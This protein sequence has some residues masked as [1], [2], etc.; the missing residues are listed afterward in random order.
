MTPFYNI[1]QHPERDVGATFGPEHVGGATF[2]PESDVWATFG[3]EHVGGA[4]F[5]PGSAMTI[6]TS[7]RFC[8]DV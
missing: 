6:L 3:L 1:R 4:T 5:G 8:R 7:S 2:G